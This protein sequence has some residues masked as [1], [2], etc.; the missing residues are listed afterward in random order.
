MQA[1][2]KTTPSVV[3]AR[4]AARKKAKAAEATRSKKQGVGS[5]DPT[6]M[7][8]RDS[9]R[10]YGIGFAWFREAIK[11]GL[12]NTK[13]GRVT[14]VLGKDLIEFIASGKGEAITMPQKN[15]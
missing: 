3:T 1:T 15:Q 10:L 5:I 6:H 14:F 13:A 11:A 2:N 8:N 9:L 12:P 7:Y 4:R